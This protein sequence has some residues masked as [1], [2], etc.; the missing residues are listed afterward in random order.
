[1]DATKDAS[2]PEE[3]GIPQFGLR[4]LSRADS[5]KH[6]GMVRAARRIHTTGRRVVALVPAT[7][8]IGIAGLGL[9]LA[10]AF[11]DLG[12]VPVSFVDANT[13]APALSELASEAFAGSA[14]LVDIT[15]A[16]G[17]RVTTSVGPARAG[18]ALPELER[19]L[20]ELSETS[21]YVLVDATGFRELGEH[22]RLYEVVDGV[23]IVAE[24]GRTA[25][26]VVRQ[27]YS[28]VPAARIMGVLLVG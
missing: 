14:G 19:K 13:Q 2:D 9:H 23:L 20:A 21:R 3:D 6:A 22:L 16:R 15:V 5:E 11:S 24:S 4:W 26:S 27:Y 10:H 25:D 8:S 17:I 7:P 1:M 28:E 12:I 18:L